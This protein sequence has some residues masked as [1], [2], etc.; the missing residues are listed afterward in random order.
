MADTMIEFLQ[1]LWGFKP[2]DLKILIWQKKGK[3]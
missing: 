2:E 3:K 1:E